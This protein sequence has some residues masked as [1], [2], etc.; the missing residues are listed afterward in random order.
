MTDAC[1]CCWGVGLLEI[2]LNLHELYYNHFY[3]NWWRYACHGVPC[4]DSS[5]PNLLNRLIIIKD[6]L[7]RGTCYPL[8]AIRPKIIPIGIDIIHTQVLS[9]LVP[10]PVPLLVAQKL[11]FLRAT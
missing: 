7:R 10:R 2:I 9:S 11:S 4:T 1:S 6:S 8:L 3:L 5:K